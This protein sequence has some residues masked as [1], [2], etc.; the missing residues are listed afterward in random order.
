MEREKDIEAYLK[1]EFEKLGC[2]FP[3]WMSPG[4]DGVPDRI[5]ILPWG[6]VAFIELKTAKGH[7]SGPQIIWQRK[8]KK[9]KCTV[10]TLYGMENARQLIEAVKA[11]EKTHGICTARISDESDP[12]DN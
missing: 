5:L 11:M 4:N 10:L 7:L 9:R 8:L 1:R 3:K 2:L 6:G 12:E